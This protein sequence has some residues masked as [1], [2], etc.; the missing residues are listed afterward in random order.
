MVSCKW[1][2]SHGLSS[3][4]APVAVIFLGCVNPVFE[5]YQST[6][7]FGPSRKVFMVNNK[8]YYQFPY[9]GGFVTYDPYIGAYWSKIAPNSGQKD[10]F[11]PSKDFHDSDIVINGCLIYACEKAEKIRRGGFPGASRAQ[12]IGFRR[13]QTVGH[14][15]VVYD[16]RGRTI[17][18]DN[19]RWAFVSPW[20][21]RT[22]AQALRIAQQF[23]RSVFNGPTSAVFYGD[24]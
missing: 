17:A 4:L 6:E 23:N 11:D 15:F 2:L 12:V 18:E 16:Y 24:F 14:S 19:T 8:Y 1:L 9:R 21:E 3:F 7:I 22:P 13:V 5:A 10:V 20:T